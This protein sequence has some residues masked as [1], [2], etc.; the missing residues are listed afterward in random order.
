MITI[1]LIFDDLRTYR[2]ARISFTEF[3]TKN[4]R[5][6]PS[7]WNNSCDMKSNL[8]YPLTEMI[9]TVNRVTATPTP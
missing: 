3:K 2:V 1:V 7:M 4:L 8:W 9:L 5:K 6:F